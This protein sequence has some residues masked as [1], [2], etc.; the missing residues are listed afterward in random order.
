MRRVDHRDPPRD[1][2]RSCSFDGK[3]FRELRELF[4]V[5][6]LTFCD[7]CLGLLDE[8]LPALV[9]RACLGIAR[10]TRTDRCARCGGTEGVLRPEHGLSL[11]AAC[12]RGGT[13][14][15]R[16]CEL[17]DHGIDAAERAAE[18]RDGF[19]CASCRA[20]EVHH[21]RLIAFAQR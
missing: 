12:V 11:C 7:E 20:S 14:V 15:G 21:A 10:G 1:T 6:D 9:M 8:I 13:R 5:G 3:G 17:C 19:L 16:W 4:V 18:I 2:S